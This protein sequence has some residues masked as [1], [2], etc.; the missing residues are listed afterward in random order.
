M[1]QREC[2]QGSISKYP[3]LTVMKEDRLHHGELEDTHCAGRGTLS[4]EDAGDTVAGSAGFCNVVKD[5]ESVIVILMQNTPKVEE[6]G[7]VFEFLVS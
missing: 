2:A 7:D 4:F 5:G 1:E 6:L 3:C